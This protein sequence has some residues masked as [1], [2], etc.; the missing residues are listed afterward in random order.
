MAP[1]E[2]AA[3]P[4]VLG[5]DATLDRVAAG[6][7]LA[8]FGDGEMKCAK[9][10]G[11]SSQRPDPSMARELCRILLDPSPGCLPAIPTMDPR[12]PRFEFWPKHAARF[13]TILDVGR[14]Y[15][16]A[17]VGRPDV[18][19]WIDTADY[20][21]KFRGLWRGRGVAIVASAD[22]TAWH[23]ARDAARIV[24]PATDAYAA[25]G[26]LERACL[27]ARPDIVLIAAGPTATCLADRLAR[28]GLHAIDIGKAPRWLAKRRN[29]I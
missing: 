29:V 10:F 5:E 4:R 8:R 2:I 3:W 28:R 25:I 9:G 19:P 6:A 21:R 24:C 11:Y 26:M 7:S 14:V 12:S 15:G 23:M 16:S 18:S 1:G 13:L 22:N 27:E 20:I 17:F